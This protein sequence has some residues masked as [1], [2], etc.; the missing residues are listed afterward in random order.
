MNDP[1]KSSRFAGRAPDRPPICDYEGTDYRTRFW[2]NK[3]RDYEDRVERIAMRRLL[4]PKGG[5]RF[6]EIGAGFGRLT[7]EMAAYQQ[8]VLL[9]YSF[10]QMADAQ[11]R[12]GKQERYLY[13]AADMY[14]M[15]FKPGVFD[16]VSVIRVLHHIADVPAALKEIRRIT[17]PDAL[18]ILEYA[19]KRHLK[20]ML[21]WALKRQAWN[22]ND[23][24]PVEF[25][26]LNFD[27]HPDYIRRELRAAGFTMK[28]QLPVSYFR[29]ELLKRIVPLAVLAG[30]DGLMQLSGLLYSP[31][32]FT[33]NTAV[34]SSPA[35]LEAADIFACP[36]CGGDL[37][38]KG[39]AMVC[40]RD[41]LRWPIRDGIYDFKVPLE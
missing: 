8:V 18:F 27:F 16:G 20:S 9:D 4:P 36:E 28:R 13:V 1:E 21:R 10:S 37:E 30:V 38:R 32:V 7:P 25:V 33:Q 14:R 41:G 15:P 29:V 26:E 12:L 39:S 5:R 34:G 22:P 11:E 23:L 19:S 17:V 24:D 2:E 35:Q 40:T 3:G 31:S 6:L